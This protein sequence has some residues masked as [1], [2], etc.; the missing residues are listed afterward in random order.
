MDQEILSVREICTADISAI[1]NYWLKAKPDFLL[2]M[3]V[4]ASKIPSGEEWNSML[5]GQ[6][7]QPYREK[8]SYCLI[9][10]ETG[11]AIGHCNVNPV[12]FGTQ[13]YM[14]LHMWNKEKRRTG[15]GLSLIR[16]SLPWFFER[17]NLQ[18]LYCQPYALNP[19]PNKTIAKAGFEFVKTHQCVPGWLNFEQEVNLWLMTREK[20][21]GLK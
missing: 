15:L 7:G 10:E 17:M 11:T 14:H 4:D 5:K 19:A 3:G 16:L 18:K 1:T 20:F 6:I 13:A 9:W 8:K 12:E 21:L 2:S